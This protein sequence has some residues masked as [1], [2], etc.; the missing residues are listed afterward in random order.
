[1]NGHNFA[2]WA[3]TVRLDEWEAACADGTWSRKMMLTRIKNSEKAAAEQISKGRLVD[4]G[5]KVYNSARQDVTELQRALIRDA[6]LTVR[7]VSGTE[8]RCAFAAEAA[9]TL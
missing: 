2:D 7:P 3:N 9:A 6:S 8:W 4:C 1:M 5:H